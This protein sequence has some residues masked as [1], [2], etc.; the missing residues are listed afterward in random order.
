MIIIVINNSR[1]RIILFHAEW[2][3][4]CKKMKPEWDNFKRDNSEV[5]EEYESE[6][7][8]RRIEKKI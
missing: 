4:H 2:C 8:N 3:G 5:C 7:N 6:G 1:V